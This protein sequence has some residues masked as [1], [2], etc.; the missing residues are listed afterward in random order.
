MSDTAYDYS[1]EMFHVGHLVADMSTAMDELGGGLGLR[2]TP[3]VTREDQPVWTPEHGLR[4]VPLK[5]CYSMEGPQ[6]IELIEGVEGTPWF[7]GDTENLHHAGVWADVPAL[8]EDL[9]SRGWTLV[10]SQKAP[11]D[12][13]GSFSYVRSPSGFLLEPVA[14][15]NKERMYRWFETGILG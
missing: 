12:G 6:R 13:Y 7:Y 10:C 1:A 5:F 2:W 3:I 14:Q 9:I 11:E 15:A 8:T 4:H